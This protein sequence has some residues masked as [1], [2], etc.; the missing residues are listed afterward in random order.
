MAGDNSLLAQKAFDCGY[1]T[2]PVDIIRSIRFGR[3]DLTP[4]SIISVEPL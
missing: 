2:G 4:D 1:R 3:C